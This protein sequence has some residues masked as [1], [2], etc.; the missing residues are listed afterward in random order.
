M[1]AV[2]VWGNEKVL[3]EKSWQW[4]YNNMSVVNAKGWYTLAEM[5]NFAFLNLNV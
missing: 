1:G 3:D 5:V 2:S 4:L